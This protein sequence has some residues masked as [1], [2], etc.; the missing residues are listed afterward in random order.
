MRRVVPDV[1]KDFEPL[2]A[3][4]AIYTK[5]V[6][7]PEIRGVQPGMN[8]YKEPI[9]ALKYFGEIAILYTPNDYCDMW[10]FGLDDKWQFDM[11]RDE[12]Y[13][14]VAMNEGMWQQRDTYYHNITPESVRATYQFGTNIIIHLITRWEDKLRAVPSSL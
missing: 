1:D 8:Y 3:N 6:Y 13:K 10:Q 9:Y 12:H 11:R 5:D 7:F 2:P 14:M 4:H